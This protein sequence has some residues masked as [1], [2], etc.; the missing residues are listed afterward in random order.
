MKKRKRL[1]KIKVGQKVM[2]TN[3]EGTVEV[4]DGH[5]FHIHAGTKSGI[6]CFRDEFRLFTKSELRG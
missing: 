6:I 4:V 3:L 2:I 5:T 1:P